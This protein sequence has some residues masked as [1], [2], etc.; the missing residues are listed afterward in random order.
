[1]SALAAARAIHFTFSIQAIGAILILLIAER[2]PDAV[3][4]RR[5]M[6]IIVI[7]ALMALPSGVAWMTLQA[8]DITDSSPVEAWAAGAVATLLW[9]SQAGLVWWVRFALA[10]ALAIA[11]AF[12][13]CRRQ[14]EARG[15]ALLVFVIAILQFVSAAWLSHAAS[16][17][18]AYRSLHLA[19]HSAHMLGASLWFGGLL[20]LAVL[21]SSAQR[22]GTAANF[23]LARDVAVRFSAIALI[24]VCIIILT[25]VT[26]L[27]MLVRGNMADAI[28]GP[29]AKLL[30]IKLILF[31]AVLVFAAANRQLL[32]PRLTGTNVARAISL[33]KC[34][35]WIELVL[36]VAILFAVG[37]LGITPP[38]VEQ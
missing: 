1:M 33:L 19:V 15:L 2:R 6:M 22:D 37:E 7:A 24:A 20:P 23:A 35:V 8:A 28:N 21:L 9:H 12:L 34:S 14:H 11:T 30:A 3:A 36:A 10:G 4:T 5:L 38:G 25:G 32:L 13:A 16:T 18:G 26:N 17:P 27:A 31:M 29:F